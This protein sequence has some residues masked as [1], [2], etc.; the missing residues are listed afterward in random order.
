MYEDLKVGTVQRKLRGV[1][2]RRSVLLNCVDGR[3]L[4]KILKGHHHERNKK[5]VSAL[6]G[7]ICR[8][9]KPFVSPQKLFQISCIAVPQHHRTM[10]LRW[11]SSPWMGKIQQKIVDGKG[12][13]RKV[14]VRWR[15]A[16]VWRFNGDKNYC[17]GPIRLVEANSIVEK[18]LFILL[19]W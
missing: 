11:V 4:F 17:L 8:L 12:T 19:S 5:P 10:A 14:A 6:S 13:H 3:F 2:T 1:K 18:T 15:N 7:R 16:T 9:I